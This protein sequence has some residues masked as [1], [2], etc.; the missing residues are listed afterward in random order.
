MWKLVS[1]KESPKADKKYV[2][3]FSDGEKV[4]HTHFG[5]AGMEDYTIHKD[6]ERR[7]RYRNRHRKDLMTNDPTRAG[8]LSWYILWNKKSLRE[9]IADYKKRFNM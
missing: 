1:I 3:T 7:E 2:A 9:S 6:D 5:A 4:K 8:F